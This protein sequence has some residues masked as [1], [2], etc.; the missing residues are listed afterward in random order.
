MQINEIAAEVPAEEVQPVAESAAPKEET[1]PKADESKGEEPQRHDNSVPISRFNKVY[2]KQKEA[3][4]ELASL[5]EQLAKQA[6]PKVEAPPDIANYTDHGEYLKDV[7]KFEGI[8]AAR[9]EFTKLQEGQKASQQQTEIQAREASASEHYRKQLAEANKKYPGLSE[10]LQNSP[11]IADISPETSLVI[12]ESKLA[13]E[14]THFLL[15]NPEEAAEIASMPASA[16]TFAIRRIEKELSKAGNSIPVPKVSKMT[17]PIA[18]V[19][20][21]KN[22]SKARTADETIEEM[23]ARLFPIG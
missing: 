15:E 2:A 20:A 19:S 23:T 8:Q 9:T 22:T 4:R 11:I 14:L 16:A 6:Q 12:A 18:P 10:A 7:A 17:A 3:E 1:V 5:R 13:G 21:A